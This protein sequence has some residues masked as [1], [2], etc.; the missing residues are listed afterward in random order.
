MVF[1]VEQSA[2]LIRRASDCSRD[3]AIG[4]DENS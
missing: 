1:G 3:E 4:I 2:G